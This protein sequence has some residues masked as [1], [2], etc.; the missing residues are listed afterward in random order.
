MQVQSPDVSCRSPAINGAE[1]SPGA[2][3]H[4]AL[5]SRTAWR[6]RSKHNAEERVAE[7]DGNSIAKPLQRTRTSLESLCQ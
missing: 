4:Q 6:H 1:T 2:A 5:P 3:L 7:I